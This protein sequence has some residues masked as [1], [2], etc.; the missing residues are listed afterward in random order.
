MC[1]S[2]FVWI[3]RRDALLEPAKIKS[4]KISNLMSLSTSRYNY[5]FF[6]G[7]LRSFYFMTEKSLVQIIY[8]NTYSKRMNKLN[9]F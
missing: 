6:M 4:N 3:Q 1:V 8:F 5:S 2:V 7:S 9:S